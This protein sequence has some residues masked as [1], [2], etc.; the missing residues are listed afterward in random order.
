MLDIEFPRDYMLKIKIYD[1]DDIGSDDLIG[2]TEIDLETRYHSKTL[3]SSPLPTE[4]TQYGPWKWRHALEP[5][6]ILQNIVTFHGFEPPTY[7]NGECQIGNYIFI[8]PSTTVDSTGSKIPSNEPSA[9]KALQNLHMIPQIGY[10]TVPEHIETRQLYNQE[11]PGISQVITRKIQGSLELWLEMYQIDNVPSSPPINIKPIIPEN[12]ELR[13]IVWSTSEV[14]MDDI[15]IITGER[16]VDIYVKGWVEG[17][18]DESQ[19]TDV[20]KK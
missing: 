17:L 2:Q 14:P 11:K 8:A 1:F 15:D 19:K 16:S 12:Y 3:V 10:H 13:I 5:S 20:H 6:Q 9:L 7:K 18:L 4:Y